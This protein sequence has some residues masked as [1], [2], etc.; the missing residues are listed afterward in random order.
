M[1]VAN[2]G[3]LEHFDKPSAPSLIEMPAA[4]AGFLDLQWT[5]YP[6][7]DIRNST[8]ATL[9]WKTAELVDMYRFDSP[10][11][12]ANEM[13]LTRVLRLNYVT[14]Q[15]EVVAQIKWGEVSSDSVVEFLAADS[16]ATVSD[17]RQKH[18]ERP[19]SRA[20]YFSAGDSHYKW[21][22]GDRR[23]EDLLCTQTVYPNLDVCYFES[24]TNRLR[25]T[26]EGQLIMD[27]LIVTL[28]LN[29]YFRETNC[30]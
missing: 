15:Y 8:V 1:A 29:L 20:R 22:P 10:D 4:P 24:A 6:G 5:F 13:P 27:E 3:F 25:I 19:N 21:S 12:A 7:Y 11:D 18:P 17:L 2:V 23:K 14:E 30:W 16:R 28:L 26:T 9:H